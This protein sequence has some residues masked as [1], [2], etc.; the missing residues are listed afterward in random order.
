MGSTFTKLFSNITMNIV[1]LGFYGSGKTTM[2]YELKLGEVVSTIPTIGFNVETVEYKNV[3]FTCWDLRTNHYLATFSKVYYEKMNGLIFMVD[4]SDDYYLRDTKCEL[5]RVMNSVERRVPV[6]VFANK[7]DLEG[8]TAQQIAKVLDTESIKDRDCLVIGCSA[9]SGE[10]IYEGLQWLDDAVKRQASLSTSQFKF[11]NTIIQ[12]CNE[13]KVE[14]DP[15]T[16]VSC[17]P[18]SALLFW[19]RTNISQTNSLNNKIN[20]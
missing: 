19:F 18:H 9:R 20:I 1:M 13:D 17:Y 2:L 11:T 12:N 6:L 10:G 3:K 16:G 7:Q 4:S 14:I 8:L 15:E 5:F